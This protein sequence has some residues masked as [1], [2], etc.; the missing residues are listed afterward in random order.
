M[1]YGARCCRRGAGTPEESKAELARLEAIYAKVK[2]TPDALP[3]QPPGQDY[4]YDSLKELE[5]RRLA[6]LEHEIT[7]LSSLLHLKVEL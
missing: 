7:R 5:R 6:A 2:A 4:V 3:P 1:G